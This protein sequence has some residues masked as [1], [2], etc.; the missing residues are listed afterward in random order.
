MSTWFI[1]G[2]STGLGRHLAQ[3]TLKRGFNVV[4]T[5]RDPAMVQDLVV[6]YPGPRFAW[7]STS[8]TKHISP[9]RFS[10]PKVASAASTSSS[11]MQVMV[12][13]Q[14]SRKLTWRTF[15]NSS[16]QTSSERLQ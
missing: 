4:V 3:E 9:R 8:P 15:T 13:A 11:T 16:R 2:C 6:E 5:A 1:T 7:R 10:K 14:L 12:I